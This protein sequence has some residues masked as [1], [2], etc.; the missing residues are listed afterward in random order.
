MKCLRQRENKI[1]LPK[2]KPRSGIKTD[3]NVVKDDFL[4]QWKDH[5]AFLSSLWFNWNYL[6]NDTWRDMWMFEDG[7]GWWDKAVPIIVCRMLRNKSG[8]SFA[9]SIK[10]SSLSLI[11]FYVRSLMQKSI[12][13]KILFAF[14][15][16]NLRR[17]LFMDVFV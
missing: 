10:T 15:P 17:P 16:R 12:C 9:F 5:L 1:A 6:L 14:L 3:A 4:I 11:E 8:N 7:N 2:I 13:N